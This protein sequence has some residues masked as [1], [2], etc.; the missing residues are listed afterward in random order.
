MTIGTIIASIF[1]FI[2]SRKTKDDVDTIKSI[3]D[4]ILQKQ[5]IEEIGLVKEEASKI[6]RIVVKYRNIKSTSTIK[7]DLDQIQSSLTIIK[8][9]RSIFGDIENNE[10]DYIYNE[11]KILEH[12]LLDIKNSYN[13]DEFMDGY[14]V[15]NISRGLVIKIDDFTAKLKEL[16]DNKKYR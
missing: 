12:K 9:N 14:D 11:I 10:C 2:N 16:K 6:K 7:K 15:S 8:E 1:A 4:E 3:K 13:V 5:N